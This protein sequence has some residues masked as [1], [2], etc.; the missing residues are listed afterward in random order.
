MGDVVEYDPEAPINLVGNNHGY[1]GI[2]DLP[3]NEKE[4]LIKIKN[5]IVKYEGHI[6]GFN[7]DRFRLCKLKKKLLIK[8]LLINEETNL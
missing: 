2:E 4:D 3:L 7:S 8:D 6:L 5:Y 1:V